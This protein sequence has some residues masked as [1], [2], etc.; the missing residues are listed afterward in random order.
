MNDE[1]YS[2][3]EDMYLGGDNMAVLTSNKPSCFVIETSN[4][5]NFIIER[6]KKKVSKAFL[7]ECKEASNLFKKR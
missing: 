2:L 5:K 3:I 4:I 6:N 1:L 7:D